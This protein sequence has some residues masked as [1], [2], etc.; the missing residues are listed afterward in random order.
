MLHIESMTNVNT[1]TCLWN[2]QIIF[3]KKKKQTNKN[4]QKIPKSSLKLISS[5]CS[6]GFDRQHIE[7]SCRS[8]SCKMKRSRCF[9]IDDILSLNN[10]KFCDFLDHIYPIEL[11]ISDNTDASWSTSYLNI[12]FD[13][14]IEGRLRTQLYDKRK[15]FNF[16]IW[17]LS[18]YM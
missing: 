7:T 6:R 2:G 8:F 3:C 14:Y 18:I 13:I 9:F 1:N 15:A 16:P 17:E 5:K 4:K 10:S 11:E 12:H